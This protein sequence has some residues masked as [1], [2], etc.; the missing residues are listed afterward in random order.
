MTKYMGFGHGLLMVRTWII[1][2][3]V[4]FVLMACSS[5]P[6]P[7]PGPRGPVEPVIAEPEPTQTEPEQTEEAQALEP[8]DV[9]TRDGL[10][11]PHM[12]GRDIKRLALL[13]PFSARSARLRDEASSMMKAA[14][15]AIFDRPD[16]DALLLAFDTKGTPEG[17]RTAARAAT[18]AGVDVILGPIL[19]GSVKAVSRDARRNNIPV[20]AFST[21]QNVAGNGTYLLSFPPEA[22]IRRIVTYARET[23]IERFAFLGPESE[24]GR[25]AYEAYTRSIDMTGGQLTASENYKGRDISVMDAPAQKLANYFAKVE[26]E[27]K[28]ARQRRLAQGQIIPAS[29]PMAF[30][31]IL[32]P[33]GGTALRSLAPLLPYYEDGMADVQFLGTGLWHREETVKEPALRGGIFAGPDQQARQGFLNRYDRTYGEDPSNLASLAYDAVNFGTSVADGNVKGRY[34]RVEDNNGFY[35]ADGLVVF[36]EDGTPDRGLAVYQIRNGRFVV[37]DPAP[38]QASGPG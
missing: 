21:D 22:E 13:L 20:I 28:T 7:Y 2:L 18:Q 14:E 16:A 5:T 29:A 30:E 12:A 17:A 33:E 1:S 9:I 38:R 4:G 34:A 15:M 8:E 3:G 35:G 37:I 31:A 6:T 26:A 23:G 32:L 36:R 24:Y 10:V 25:R 19:A 27:N 11:P